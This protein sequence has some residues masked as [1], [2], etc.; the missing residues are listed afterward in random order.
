MREGKAAR[1]IDIESISP[2]LW[3]TLEKRVDLLGIKE[4]YDYLKSLSK[5][6]KI[7][8]GLKRGLM[9]DLTGEYLWF[10]I[11]IYGTDTKKPG[12]AVAMEASTGEDGGKATYFFRM[13]SRRDYPNYTN[14]EDLNNVINDLITTINKCMLEINFRREPIYLSDDRLEEPRYS[15]YWYAVK[16]MPSLRTLRRL[17]IGRVSHLSP[18][19]WRSDVMD[20]LRFNVEAEEDDVRWREEAP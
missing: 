11:P 18:E 8:I 15:R 14:I 6:D 9:G 13:L 19:Q 1:R 10:L 20:L 3:E 17:F 16:R 4:E 7:C 5:Q 2:E 12:N